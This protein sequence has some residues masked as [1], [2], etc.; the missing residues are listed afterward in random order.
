MMQD[1]TIQDTYS[2]MTAANIAAYIGNLEEE[3]RKLRKKLQEKEDNSIDVNVFKNVVMTVEETARFHGV[4]AARVRD[5]AK[6]GLIETHPDSTDAKMLFYAKTILTL[7]F[8]TLKKKKA[9][10]K[11]E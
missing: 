3:N 6:R 2:D 5:Y 11:W 10:L 9:L 4:S 8:P 7:D 1:K